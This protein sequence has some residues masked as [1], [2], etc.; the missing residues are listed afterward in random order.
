MNISP[1]DWSDYYTND[2]DKPK[3]CHVEFDKFLT[4][5]GCF[6]DGSSA[7]EIG[8]GAGSSTYYF[9]KQHNGV[10]FVGIDYNPALI[11]FGAKCLNDRNSKNLTLETGDWFKLDKKYINQF[12]GIF[13]I[14][15]FCCFKKLDS[16][17]DAIVELNPRWMAFNSLFYDGPLDVLIHIRDNNHP[18]DNDPD[19]DFNTFSLPNLQKYL[20]DRGYSNFKVQKFHMPID[21]AQPKDKSRGTYTVKTAFD[22]R[23]MFSGSVYLPWYFVYA[24]K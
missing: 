13:N 2:F 24:G 16:A 10:N 23:A 12:D 15:T 8:C 5:S 9:A 18:D 7:C 3:H 22:D 21:L 20:A 11:E 17:L 4:S 1:K 19:G 6:K 14:H